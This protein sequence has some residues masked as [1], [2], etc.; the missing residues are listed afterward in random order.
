MQER[1]WVFAPFRLEPANARLWR[2]T[3]A[4]ALPPKVFAVL[5][6][7]VE[8][9]GR[10]VTKDELLDAVWQR[11]FVSESVLKDCI[12]QLRKVLGDDAKA[13]RYIETVA[14]RGYRFIAEV[15]EAVAGGGLRAALAPC[16]WIA[17]EATHWVGREGPL[18]RLEEHLHRALAGERQLV[19]VTG[20]AGIGKT[21][22][23]TMFL[24]PAAESAPCQD[25]SVLWGLCIEHF[26]ES[27]AFLPLIEA[28]EKRCR[29]AG[30][31]CLIAKLRQ[32]APDLARANALDPRPHGA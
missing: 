8:H 15:K 21:T 3:E 31:E 16:Q 18:E 32:H 7:L 22:V 2:A 4:L 5:G 24:A 20:K 12:N 29:M 14:R 19:F 17:P 9:P 28:L 6:H 11:R 1:Q 30:G 23:V 13:P 26:G 25:L 10:L 27:E